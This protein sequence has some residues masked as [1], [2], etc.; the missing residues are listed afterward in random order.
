MSNNPTDNQP[1]GYGELFNSQAATIDLANVLDSKKILIININPALSLDANKA[2]IKMMGLER[3]RAEQQKAIEA[4]QCRL[5]A[6]VI[7]NQGTE[8]KDHCEHVIVDKIYGS[9]EV[10]SHCLVCDE[11]LPEQ[12]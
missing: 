11:W 2:L 4:E 7:A 6:L 12:V 8:L 1:K 9:N 3:L 10:G 5:T